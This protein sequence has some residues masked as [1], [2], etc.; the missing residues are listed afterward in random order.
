MSI[1]INVIFTLII[2]LIFLGLTYSCHILIATLLLS[3]LLYFFLKKEVIKTV[4]IN[5]LI[6][7]I[8]IFFIEL[9]FTASNKIKEFRNR[10]NQNKITII[11]RDSKKEINHSQSYITTVFDKLGYQPIA[12]SIIN[13]K[14]TKKGKLIFDTN[15]TINHN[16]LRIT[17]VTDYKSNAQSVL[18]MGCSF[19]YGVGLQD[20]QSLP[21][22]FNQ[23]TA[24]K[25]NVYNFGFSNYGPHQMLAILEND[26][27]KKSLINNKVK[28]VFYTAILDHINRAASALKPKYVLNDE[29]K[30][31]FIENYQIETK[32]KSSSEIFLEHLANHSKSQIVNVIISKIYPETQPI[33]QINDRDR[34]L[35]LQI[36]KKSQDLV[37]KKYHAK[38]T[39]IL[40][41][42]IKDDDNLIAENEYNLKYVTDGFKKLG[43]NYILISDILSDYKE[44]SKKYTISGNGHPSALANEKIADYLIKYIE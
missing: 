9:F 37:N 44:D 28:Y 43:I 35:F 31:V 23:K 27:E 21:Y 6:L 24:N 11:D 34:E 16:N 33:Y 29:N 19:T 36:V 32:K 38:F 25:F 41:D 18:F 14:N 15:Y 7:F 26:I 20:Q 22:V 39:V 42:L 40:W 10:N 2:A 13:Q 17:G 12:N 1:I 8:F 5:F 30:L 4:S 3:I